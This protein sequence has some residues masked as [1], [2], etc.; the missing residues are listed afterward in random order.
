MCISTSAPAVA[1]SPVMDMSYPVIFADAAII[2]PF[3]REKGKILWNTSTY[4]FS[5][6]RYHF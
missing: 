1:K 2:I 3:P 4:K 5:V 6:G